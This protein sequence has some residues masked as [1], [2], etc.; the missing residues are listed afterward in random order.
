MSLTRV[1]YGNTLKVD[2]TNNHVGFGTAT[3]QA[4]I[5]ATLAAGGDW[6]ARFQNTTS[7]TPYGVQVYD[8]AS[9]A[10]G[11]PL[12]QVTNSAGSGAYFRVD[13]G[14]GYV[15]TPNQPAFNAKSTNAIAISGTVTLTFNSVRNNVTS[16]YNSSNGTFTAPI[17]GWYLFTH[18][19]LYY[20]MSASEYLD[21][22][23]YV[24]GSQ[25]ARYE[26]TGNSGEHTQVDY[27]EIIYLNANDTF[28][29]LAS[30]RNIGSYNMYAQENHFSGRL[31]G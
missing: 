6:V 26:Q 22:Y 12:L 17:A 4:P 25:W 28:K 11:Y 27:S 20:A 13:S 9:S 14:T 2:G 29:I 24:N 15:T 16:S 31:L 18:K 7:S 5:D 23:P 1:N 30:N 8:A 19:G 3:P 10:N 21:L